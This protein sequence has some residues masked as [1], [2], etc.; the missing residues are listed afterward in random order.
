MLELDL[1]QLS[2]QRSGRKGVEPS[3]P[4]SRG[5]SVQ[6]WLYTQVHRH[7]LGYRTCDMI[8][9]VLRIAIRSAIYNYD[10]YNRTLSNSEEFTYNINSNEHDNNIIITLIPKLSRDTS[11]TNFNKTVTINLN[12][13]NKT[14]N[15]IFILAGIPI[16]HSFLLRTKNML[17]LDLNDNINAKQFM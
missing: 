16:D 13:L 2:W 10:R 12:M 17:L 3:T 8:Q 14:E 9:A 6:E 7:D 11:G 4:K 1:E 15:N 5:E